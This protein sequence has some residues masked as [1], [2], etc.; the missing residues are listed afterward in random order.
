[1][2]SRVGLFNLNFEFFV[3]NPWLE[4]LSHIF[5]S[6]AQTDS[7]TRAAMATAESLAV[8]PPTLLPPAQFNMSLSDC[9][10]GLNPLD[11]L[12][13]GLL[14]VTST[15]IRGQWDFRD[16]G[17]GKFDVCLNKAH[18]FCID[19]AATLITTS[20]P[21]M[22]SGRKEVLVYFSVFRCIKLW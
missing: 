17:R 4:K 15:T 18:L 21:R 9:T 5:V 8:A 16:G 6:T 14:L 11:L 19:D 7:I 10:I 12:S 22:R 13:R 20:R 2:I 3:F 1:V